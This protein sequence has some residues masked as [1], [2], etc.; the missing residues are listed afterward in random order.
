MVK[1][2]GMGTTGFA[3]RGYPE[4]GIAVDLDGGVEYATI[5]YDRAGGR[6]VTVGPRAA[7]VRSAVHAERPEVH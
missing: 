4:E 1:T 6:L 7:E 5:I 2:R 3:G